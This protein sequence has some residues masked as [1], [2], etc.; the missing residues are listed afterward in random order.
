MAVW[1]ARAARWKLA[2][3]R[4]RHGT[5]TGQY[6]QI[7]GRVKA[8]AIDRL[9][10]LAVAVELPQQ[11]TVP[12]EVGEPFEDLPR[13]GVGSRCGQSHHQSKSPVD[14]EVPGPGRP[15]QC[16][17]P[18]RR[19]PPQSGCGQGAGTNGGSAD[20]ACDRRF[21]AA[22]FGTPR[23]YPKGRAPIPGVA[24]FAKSGRSFHVFKAGAGPFRGRSWW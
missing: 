20:P 15:R 10:Q 22:A 7:K 4:R 5:P 11:G 12:F 17:R 1:L 24:G 23:G 3:S 19:R 18:V 2:W 21:R 16:G 6:R 9:Q 8:V 14:R 13:P